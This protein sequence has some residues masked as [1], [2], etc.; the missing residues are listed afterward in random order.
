MCGFGMFHRPGLFSLAVLVAVAHVWAQ[1]AGNPPDAEDGSS[2]AGIVDVLERF[3][4]KNRI[5]L[6]ADYASAEQAPAFARRLADPQRATLE[7]LL[8]TYRRKAVRVGSILILIRGRGTYDAYQKFNEDRAEKIFGALF[9]RDAKVQVRVSKDE[10]GV[11]RVTARVSEAPL[12]QFCESFAKQTGWKI[13]VD[14]QVENTRLFAHWDSVSPGEVVEALS[15]LLQTTVETKLLLSEQ[16]REERKRELSQL[17]EQNS[18]VKR[19]VRSDELL[20]DL[21]SVL[22]PEEM[23]R[24]RRGEMV[25]VRLS[26]LPEEVYDRALQYVTFAIDTAAEMGDSYLAAVR[27]RLREVEIVLYLPSVSE[28]LFGSGIGIGLKHPDDGVWCHF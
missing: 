10:N 18:M 15:V 17:L 19:L 2:T 23:E 1:P 13:E 24:Y 27:D 28:G 11:M 26:R 21:L 14:P 20:P 6:L 8:Q 22:T 12:K 4:T 25:E 5:N 7:D 3:A 16:Q 9:W